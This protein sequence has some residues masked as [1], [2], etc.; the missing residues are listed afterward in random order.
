MRDW[1]KW[2]V[3]EPKEGVRMRTAGKQSLG[4][5]QKKQIRTIE[6]SCL[7]VVAHL[8]MSERKIIE[9][10]ASSWWVGAVDLCKRAPKE[11]RQCGKTYGE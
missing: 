1:R 3:Q 5:G 6:S 7:V 10:L 11:R 4:I 9:T 2:T 8:V